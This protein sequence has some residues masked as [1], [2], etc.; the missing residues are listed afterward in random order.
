MATYTGWDSGRVTGKSDVV[1]EVLLYA[2]QRERTAD[3]GPP[4]SSL[5]TIEKE[6]SQVQ[7]A[8]DLE[9]IRTLTVP[10]NID[11]R[12][13]VCSI[14]N[15]CIKH[16]ADKTWI[17]DYALLC[18][19]CNA[20]PKTP[21][22]LLIV[23]SEFLFLVKDKFRDINFDNIF[24]DNIVTVFDFQIHFFV[25]RCFS[26]ADEDFLLNEN[27]TL[28]YMTVVKSILM[29][30]DV[31]PHIRLKR[32]LFK[33]LA[34]KKS[35]SVAT[36]LL[37][38]QSIETNA[39]FTSLLFYMWAGTN[40][41]SKIPLINLTLIKHNYIKQIFSRK[42]I[43]TSAGPILL[44]QI[45][46]SVTKNDTTTVCLLCELM[47]ASSQDFGLL[48]FI[49]DR[50]V[51]YCYNNVKLIDRT[52]FVLAE[53]LEQSGLHA[54][55]RKTTDYSTIVTTSKECY[56][57]TE[58]KLDVHSYLILRQVGATGLYK[59]FFCDPLC[60]ANARTTQPKILFNTTDPHILADF[61]IAICYRNEYLSAVDKSVWLAIEI[62]K[63][64]QTTRQSFKNK[65]QVNEFL[66]E[67]NLILDKN[68]F[69]LVDPL[70]TIDYYV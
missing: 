17:L 47:A 58:Y 67:F 36:E 39:R 50:I 37:A 59:H 16:D 60:R 56:T 43:E 41:L 14:I 68:D 29:R 48:Q 9:E 15:I 69:D 55:I 30:Q 12:C 4:D 35:S 21:L 22:S 31:V 66:K 44:A 25:N 33:K 38:N 10:L 42:T 51:T 64:F 65:T 54:K 61:K 18:Y 13:N 62:F 11:K 52:Q 7:E 6:L 24:V 19:K 5:G 63:A 23:T 45:P 34:P 27:I 8:D 2:H 46:L 49:R 57:H 1:N 70:F 53:I 32:A 3:Q 40:V 20:A 28:N 26:N